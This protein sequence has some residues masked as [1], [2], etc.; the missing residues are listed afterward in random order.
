MNKNLGPK[1]GITTLDEIS[2]LLLEHGIVVGNQDKFVV[3]KAFRI[4]DIS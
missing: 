3:A 2:G 4:S 1:L